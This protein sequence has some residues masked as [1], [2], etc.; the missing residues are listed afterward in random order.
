LHV[1][2]SLYVCAARD[3]LNFALAASGAPLDHASNPAAMDVGPL[4]LC[5]AA[6]QLQA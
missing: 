1:A 2:A 4:S 5:A 6:L 3:L